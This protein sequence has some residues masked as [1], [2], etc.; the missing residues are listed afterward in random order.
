M[1]PITNDNCRVVTNLWLM[2]LFESQD[3]SGGTAVALGTLSWEQLKRNGRCLCE[4]ANWIFIGGKKNRATFHA[5][6]RLSGSI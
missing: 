2:W 5:E 6:G 1:L 3:V 4:C